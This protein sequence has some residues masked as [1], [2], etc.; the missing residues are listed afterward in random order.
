[1]CS[2]SPKLAPLK[3][4]P[5]DRLCMLLALGTLDLEHTNEV[6]ALLETR[7]GRLLD[8][9]LVLRR[10]QQHDVY[11]LI[12]RNLQGLGSTSASPEIRVPEGILNHLRAL[13]KVNAYRNQLL[14]MELC[15]VLS[16]LQEARIPA[17]NLKG[18]I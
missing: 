2:V 16:L 18:L 12:W 9:Q 13:Y 4:A 17:I 11:P 7:T 8:W 10:A 5:E 1:M 3:L 6:V 15:G 14:S